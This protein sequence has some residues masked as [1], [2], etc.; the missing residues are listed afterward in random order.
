M[1]PRNTLLAASIAA[2]VLPVIAAEP[3]VAPTGAPA[4]QETKGEDQLINRAWR[5]CHG[6]GLKR[7]WRRSQPRRSAQG[8]QQNHRRNE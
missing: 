5:R 6:L 4:T 7:I 2:V 3:P 8:R 1:I